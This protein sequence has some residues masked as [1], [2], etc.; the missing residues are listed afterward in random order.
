[1]SNNPIARH[2]LIQNSFQHISEEEDFKN[3]SFESV[4]NSKNPVFQKKN[5]VVDPKR[6][7]CLDASHE[8]HKK[9]TFV[10]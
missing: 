3:R 5:T 4:K 9:C 7:E 8:W 1:M 10:T 6:G 2:L